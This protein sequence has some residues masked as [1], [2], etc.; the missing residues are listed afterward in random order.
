[1]VFV[2]FY[3]KVCELSICRLKEFGQFMY[4]CG[5]NIKHNIN[6]SVLMEKASEQDTPNILRGVGLLI[7]FG[8]SLMVRAPHTEI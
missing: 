5:V 8:T 6:T 1:M 2:Y 4:L 7:L 3:S